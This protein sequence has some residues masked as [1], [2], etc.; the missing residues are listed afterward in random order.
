[1]EGESWAPP[2]EACS[3]VVPFLTLQVVSWG[4]HKPASHK[5]AMVNSIQIMESSCFSFISNC[6]GWKLNNLKC[7]CMWWI[8]VYI[9]EPMFVSW[10]LQNHVTMNEW[11]DNTLLLIII[12]A[13][14]W[15]PSL[16]AAYYL[17]FLL[18]SNR[19]V[20]TGSGKWTCFVSN[21]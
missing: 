15:I 17:F 10:V 12:F 8:R 21:F 7:P 3:F 18:F 13:C 6:I 1:M 4:T 14:I 20:Y 2:Q 19:F 9:A 5:T 11:H 16:Q